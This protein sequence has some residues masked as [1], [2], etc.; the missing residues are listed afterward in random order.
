MKPVVLGAVGLGVFA[1]AIAA[2]F[3]FLDDGGGSQTGQRAPS[4][5][6]AVAKGPAPVTGGAADGIQPM[7]VEAERLLNRGDT[8]AAKDVYGKAR[9]Q[10]KRQNRS[11]E[12]TSELQSH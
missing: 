6:T 12:H 4:P 8:P 2:V 10:A 1:A 7:L 5:A 11:E 3:V 9:A